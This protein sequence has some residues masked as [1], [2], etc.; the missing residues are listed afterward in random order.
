MP[1][2]SQCV[3]NNFSCSGGKNVRSSLRL[4]GN[5]T[6]RVAAVRF[7]AFAKQKVFLGD[8]KKSVNYGYATALTQ[9]YI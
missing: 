9:S 6:I 5:K 7:I 4:E 1:V 8:Y 3:K 2:V